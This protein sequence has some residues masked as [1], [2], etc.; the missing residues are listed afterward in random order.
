[1]GDLDFTFTPMQK[2]VVENAFGKALFAAREQILT[3]CNF[4]VRVDQGILRDTATTATKGD[5]ELDVVYSQPYA[6]RVYFTGTPSK[7]QNPNASLQ[8]C[9]KAQQTFGKDWIKILEKGMADN[10]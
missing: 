8:W 2:E 10:L 7:D 3:D 4:Y 1:M 9:E 5:M 6:A